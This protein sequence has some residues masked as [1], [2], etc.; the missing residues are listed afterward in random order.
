M[1]FFIT[2]ALQALLVFILYVRCTAINPADPSIMSNFD[3]RMKKR[4]NTDHGLS[5]KDLPR[6]FDGMGTGDHSS[7][8]SVSRSSFAGDNS[9]KKGSLGELGSVDIQV[10][11]TTRKSRCMFGAIFCAV[12]V[13]EDCRK[14]DDAAEQQGSEEALFCTLCNA[15][16]TRSGKYVMSI[17][18]L[19]CSYIGIID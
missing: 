7:I 8:S 19:I 9:S 18:N 11:T 6:K 12:F 15:Q 4:L 5:V 3:S 10:E 16:V 14:Q 13:Y 1:I 2:L 17:N